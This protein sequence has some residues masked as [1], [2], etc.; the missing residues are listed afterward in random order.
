MIVETA[1]AKI[2]LALHVRRRRPDGYHELETL[3]AFAAD[4]DTIT[5]EEAAEDRFDI[6][7]P[8]AQAL[9]SPSGN[10][11]TPPNLV[12]H[13]RDAFRHHQPT[14][15]VAITL[16][17]NLPIASGIGGGSA[18]AAA[19]LRALARVTGIDPHAPA[20][21]AIAEHLGA[22]V[23]ACLLGR[24]TLGTGK[25][26]ALVPI[27]GAPGTPLLLVNPNVAVSTAVVF[28][29]WDGIDRGALG[30]GPLLDRARAARNDLESPARSLAPV[31]GEVRTLLDAAPGAI[32]SRMSGSGATCFAL[33][34]TPEARDTAATAAAARGWWSLASFMI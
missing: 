10:G 26:E 29:G 12:T 28:A 16:T 3:F 22:D 32:L 8:F 23:P 17:K 4:G 2:N 14:P 1:P 11:K 7:G 34:D 5:V 24:T 33:F 31:I 25:G 15:P 13:A 18:D 27:E 6:T 9:R 20:L 19:T 21:F 30:E